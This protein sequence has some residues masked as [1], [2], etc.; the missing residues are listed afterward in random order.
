[1]KTVIEKYAA[2]LKVQ[3]RT[4]SLT[5][6]SKPLYALA[7]LL[8]FYVMSPANYFKYILKQLGKK[9]VVLLLCKP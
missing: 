9:T 7:K 3:M 1:M 5:Q 2:M 6:G 4:N 8:C